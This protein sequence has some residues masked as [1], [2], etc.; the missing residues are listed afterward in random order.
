MIYV[1]VHSLTFNELK[2]QMLNIG[3]LKHQQPLINY[4]P[5]LSETISD[6]I[7]KSSA[8]RA[9][10]DSSLHLEKSFQEMHKGEI[11]NWI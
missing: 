10:A 4:L 7:M 3:V 5:S 9:E 1:T 11:S 6:L 8:P 2:F